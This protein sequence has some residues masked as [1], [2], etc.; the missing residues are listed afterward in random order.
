MRILIAADDAFRAT[1]IKAS[2]T[3]R[4]W[5]CDTID[6]GTNGLQVAE[7]APGY[8]IIL[9]DLTLSGGDVA[10]AV[11]RLHTAYSPAPILILSYPAGGDHSLKDLGFG[12][13]QFLTAPLSRS[14]LV[15]RIHAVIQRSTG[16]RPSV[17]RTG[18]LV[19][20]LDCHSVSV[21]NWAV[22]L[23]VKEYAI[24]ELLSRHKGTILTKEML[25]DHLYGGMDEP[26]AKIID[27]FVC[28]LRKKLAVA[29][30]GE[31]YIKTVW[32]RGYVLGDAPQ[33]DNCEEIARR[34]SHRVSDRKR[35][36]QSQ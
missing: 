27:V 4:N 17:I 7:A 13:D 5:V 30:G 18:K 29:T 11:R 31:H 9:L 23:T 15:A 28:K 34:Q 33:P 24:L 19:V 14:Q 2:L 22:H 32:G 3:N 26:K 25:L 35:F 16:H 10:Y 1:R 8:N 36:G 21:D 12:A 6:L 20:Q